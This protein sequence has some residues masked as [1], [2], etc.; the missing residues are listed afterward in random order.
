MSYFKL[1]R[2]LYRKQVQRR[3]TMQPKK[4]Q[5]TV[6]KIIGYDAFVK[7]YSVAV[8]IN[9]TYYGTKLMTKAEM[10]SFKVRTIENKKT[11]K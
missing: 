2:P 9:S 5:G 10:E 6:F 4:T 1:D 3:K 11:R 8:F 7:K